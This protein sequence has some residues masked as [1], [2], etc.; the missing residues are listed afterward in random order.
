ME[1]PLHNPYNLDEDCTNCA[2]R[3][4]CSDTVVHGYG[5]VGADILVIGSV[6]DSTAD[7]TGLPFA[8]HP[9]LFELLDTLG[10]CEE[11][12][13]FETVEGVA[14]LPSLTNIYLTYLIRCRHDGAVPCDEEITACEPFLNAELR[15]IN[16]EILVPVGDLALR[17][18]AAEHTTSDPASLTTDV[19]HAEKIYGR[20]FEVVPSK[21]LNNMDE[22]DFGALRETFEELLAQDYRQTKGASVR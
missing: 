2:E 18:I 21:Q 17:E 16:P 9:S 3:A 8:G 6:P 5:D 10:F 19:H 20:G 12:P 15:T 1:P 7:A 22:T 11:E 13:A 4:A 14:D